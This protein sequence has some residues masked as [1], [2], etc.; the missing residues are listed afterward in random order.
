M[1]SVKAWRHNAAG[2]LEPADDWGWRDVIRVPV[3]DKTPSALAPR[4][5]AERRRWARQACRRNR[6]GARRVPAPRNFR[7]LVLR[8]EV[9]RLHRFTDGHRTVG[10]YLSGRE[11][12]EADRVALELASRGTGRPQERAD[13]PGG[14]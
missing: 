4:S 2:T 3:P 9:Y 11:P 10:L 1:R 13:A 8:H 5:R 14:T 7:A 12:T 6:W